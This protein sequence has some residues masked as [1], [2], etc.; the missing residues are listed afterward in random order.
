MEV[1]EVV[2]VVLAVVEEVVLTIC[3]WTDAWE[4]ADGVTEQV[5]GCLF[6][7]ACLLLE[8]PCFVWFVVR[9]SVIQII[10]TVLSHPPYARLHPGFSNTLPL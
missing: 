5:T 8:W 1:V 6:A 7:Y 2:E 3:C 4:R 10:V 9:A